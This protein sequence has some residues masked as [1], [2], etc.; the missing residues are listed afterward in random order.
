[1][2]IRSLRTLCLVGT[3]L[4]GIF[5]IIIPVFYFIMFLPFIGFMF[6]ESGS[7]DYIMFCSIILLCWIIVIVFLV[8]MLY[9]NTVLGLDRKD[10]VVAKRWMMIGAIC[11]FVFGGGVI[12]LVIFLIA[13]ISIDDAIKAMYYYPPPA[14]YPYP[15]QYGQYPPQPQYPAPNIKLKSRCPKCGQYNDS[16]ITHCYYCHEKLK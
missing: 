2:D 9:Q 5:G 11:G 16:R 13:Y 14:Y 7:G 6:S 1:M 8:Y 4:F 12:T 10:Y 15:P 3:V